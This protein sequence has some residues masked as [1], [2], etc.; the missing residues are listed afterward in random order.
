MEATMGRPSI[1]TARRSSLWF[2]TFA[3]HHEGGINVQTFLSK[4]SIFVVTFGIQTPLEKCC[5]KR[6][7]AMASRCFWNGIEAMSVGSRQLQTKFKLKGVG[8]VLAKL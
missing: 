5:W 3:L 2:S 7:E 6:I 1:G 4:I 8:W